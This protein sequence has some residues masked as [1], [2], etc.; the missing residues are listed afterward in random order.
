[1]NGQ[2]DPEQMK[3]LEDMKKQLMGKILGKEAFERLGRVRAADPQLAMQV[4]LY[5]L[6]LY[7][8]GGLKERISDEQLKEILTLLTRKK[9]MTITRK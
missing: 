9:E 4:E 1:M 3:Q 5:L 6:Q 2:P 7:Q 8:S